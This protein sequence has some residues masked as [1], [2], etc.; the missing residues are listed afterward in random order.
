[1][2]CRPLSTP[3]VELWDAASRLLDEDNFIE[4]LR[5][6][7]QT[8][9][10]PRDIPKLYAHRGY[11][12]YRAERYHEAVGDFD[13]AI[14]LVPDA[15]NTLFLRGRCLEETDDF[16][17]A[18]SD[19]RRVIAQKPDTADAH[20]HLGFCLEKLE[21]F[22]EARAAYEKALSY[23]AE[24]SLALAGMKELDCRRS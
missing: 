1:M 17:R 12:R 20:A 15:I 9:A 10:Q 3:E 19:Y 11:G 14:E 4:A 23:D 8:L 7:D 22:E 18:I 6:L 21:R 24:E 2:H 5:L 16:E 13:R